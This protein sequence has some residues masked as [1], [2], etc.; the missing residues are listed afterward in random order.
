MTSRSVNSVLDANVKAVNLWL[1][2]RRDDARL[3]LQ[4]DDVRQPAESLLRKFGDKSVATVEELGVSEIGKQLAATRLSNLDSQKYFG[5]AVLDTHRRV[6]ATSHDRL[7]TVELPIERDIQERIDQS[8][9]T[10]SRPFRLPVAIADEGSYAKENAPLMIAVA[11]ISEGVRAIGCLAL[12]INPLD[13]FTEI[14]QATQ[15]GVTGETIAFDR[16]GLLLSRSRFESQLRQCGLLSEDP[17]I[18]SPLNIYVRDP[19]FDTTITPITKRQ[20]NDAPLTE[21]ADQAT[22]GA[23]GSNVVGYRDL[24]GKKVVGSW[25]WLGD[26]GFG[27]ATEIDHAEVYGPM[28][29]LRN[30][31]LLLAGAIALASLGLFTLASALRWFADHGGPTTNPERRLG[32][33][34]LGD[35][36]GEGGMG[37]VY[38]GRHE[39]LRRDVAVKVLEHSEV[40]P[41]SLSRFER[42]VRMTARLRHPNT[43]D[44]YD[45]GHTPDGTFFYVMEYI[46][47]ISLLDLVRR[48][49]RQSPE[50]VIYLLLQVCGSLSEAHGQSLV[51]RD[52]KPANILLTSH[53]GLY[54]MIKVVDFGLVKQA[55]HDTMEVTQTSSITGTPLYMSPE[56]VRDAS[57]VDHRSDIYSLGAVGYHLLTGKALFDGD[58]PA[59]V[60]AKQLHETP[61]R[62]DTRISVDLPEDLQN[63]LMACL[64][65]IPSDRPASADDLAASLSQCTHHSRWTIADARRWWEEVYEPS[66]IRPKLDARP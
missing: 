57:T 65:K 32:Q 4:D 55:D 18:T 28:S 66:S 12:F 64:Q 49:G 6:L 35:V 54:D 38:Q 42:E 41:R 25:C 56:S 14:L 19:G 30:S 45:Y 43:I 23:T 8:Q 21:M 31:F 61:V 50:R 63:V 22:R 48:Y 5:W 24:R 59:D 11:P 33:Y 40:T 52:I 58:N 7:L 10:V 1:D 34:N 27:V 9:S 20:L 44:I 47:G 16:S 2:E 15:I 51:H 37:C 36:I 17:V 39:L 26:Y 29:I 46:D 3:Y 62:P 60:C 13:K 53:A